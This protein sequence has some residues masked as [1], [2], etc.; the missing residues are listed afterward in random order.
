MLSITNCNIIYINIIL[1]LFYLESILLQTRIYLFIKFPTQELLFIDQNCILRLLLY[2]RSG[3]QQ[4]LL[5]RLFLLF[6]TRLFLIFPTLYLPFTIYNLIL[7]QFPIHLLLF[8]FY[9]NLCL[10]LPFYL[11]QLLI[12]IL[13]CSLQFYYLIA[14]YPILSGQCFHL[15]TKLFPSPFLPLVLP[16]FLLQFLFIEYELLFQKGALSLHYLEYVLRVRRLFTEFIEDWIGLFL[17][18]YAGGVPLLF[19]DDLFQLSL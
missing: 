11:H 6:L 8:L 9:Y 1:L 13:Y 19:L 16:L 7:L 4:L 15:Q 12:N 14:V 5:I 2:L 10:I 18:G 17:G 3:Y